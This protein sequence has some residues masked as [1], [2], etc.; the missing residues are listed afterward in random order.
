M[1]AEV[2]SIG[3]EL[4][5]G[6]RLDTN[7]Q[8]LSQ[9]LGD[10]GI[11]V[12]FHTTVGDTLQDNIDV[13]R[14]AAQRADIVV[15]T[16]GLGPTADDLTREAMSAAFGLPL[17]LRGEALQHIESLFSKRK[18]AM[19]DRNRVQAMFPATSEIIENPHGTAPGI[20]LSITN[21]TSAGDSHRCRLF[22]LPGV[23][24]E[25]REMMERTVEPRLIQE[26]GAG[27]KR[28]RY[29]SIKLFGIGES[30]V[31][32]ELPDLIARNREPKVGI[33]VS[34]ATI[35]LR[36]AARTETEQEFQ[37]LIEP[38]REEILKTFGLLVFGEGEVDLQ[39]AVDA[40]LVARQ[41]RVGVTEIGAGTWV[42]PMLSCVQPNHPFGLVEARWFRRL[43]ESAD[44]EGEKGERE[45]GVGI[46]QHLMQV[47]EAYR[48]A[49]G[50]DY[51]LAVGVYPDLEHVKQES[52]LP[53]T[54]FSIALARRGSN[55]KGTTVSLGGHPEVFYARLAKTALNFLRLELLRGPMD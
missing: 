6:Q 40:L 37:Q 33:T 43:S 21:T 3:D 5:S 47:A 39:H 15:A 12:A 34:N 9:R 19:P 42:A 31:E 38:T 51:Y 11:A 35:T 44:G 41:V 48:E 16:G 54:D 20:D 8:Y 23:P 17:E 49:S 29:H 1:K 14:I 10:L 53:T 2:I 22:A 7:S 24:A 32:K 4:T 18:R 28:W 30:D 13:F 55:P 27:A 52:S 26:L 50:L 46:Q 36:I 45:N 25:M